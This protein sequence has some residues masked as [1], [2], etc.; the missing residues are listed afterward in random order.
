MNTERDKFLTEAIG[1]C[2]HKMHYAD[3]GW[4]CFTCKT[5]GCE[6]NPYQVY[7]QNINFST[8]D[9]FFKLWNWSQKQEWWDIFIMRNR[10]CWDDGEDNS[11]TINSYLINPDHFADTVNVFLKENEK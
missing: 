6:D 2:W 1:E 8:P 10:G 7:H 5:E 4:H 11:P 9:G 3:G